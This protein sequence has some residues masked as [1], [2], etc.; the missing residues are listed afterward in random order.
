MT[1]RTAIICNA[2][3]FRLDGRV[4]GFPEEIEWTH[5]DRECRDFLREH[6]AELVTVLEALEAVARS[7]CRD[8][9]PGYDHGDVL[10]YCD[11]ARALLTRLKGSGPAR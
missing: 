7:H 1:T 10:A 4:E 3:G 11:E 9:E 2:C 8:G 5:P 6:N